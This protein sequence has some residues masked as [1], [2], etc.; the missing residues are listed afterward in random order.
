MAARPCTTNSKGKIMNTQT[1]THAPSSRRSDRASLVETL[2]QMGGTYRQRRA[3][4]RLNDAQLR[5]IGITAEAALSEA[6]RPIWDIPGYW[7]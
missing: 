7:R 2:L 6:A 5:D 4:A 3:L 1:L